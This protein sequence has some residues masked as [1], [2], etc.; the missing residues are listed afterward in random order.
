MTYHVTHDQGQVHITCPSTYI[1][2][3]DT[4]A[5]VLFEQGVTQDRGML[6]F[7]GGTVEITTSLNPRDTRSLDVILRVITDTITMMLST[8]LD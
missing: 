6:L 7:Y 8:P 5:H 4:A 2:Q 3:L 1:K